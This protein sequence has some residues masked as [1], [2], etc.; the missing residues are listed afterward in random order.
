VVVVV[1]VDGTA[2]VVG[3]TVVVAIVVAG[4][5]VGSGATCGVVDVSGSGAAAVQAERIS[6]D[7]ARTRLIAHD[8]GTD[9]TIRD[10][11]RGNNVGT[12]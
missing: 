10:R 1:V 9:P 11:A 8:P 12:E 5:A 2:D 6:A 4:A 7:A 3:P